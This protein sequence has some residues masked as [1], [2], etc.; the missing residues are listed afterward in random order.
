MADVA[1]ENATPVAADV[2]NRLLERAVVKSLSYGGGQTLGRDP[3]VQESSLGQPATSLRSTYRGGVSG[4]AEEAG[5][6][7][8]GY[9]LAR[10]VELPATTGLLLD[11]QL[12]D[13]IL[14]RLS[15]VSL[16]ARE[17]S[18]DVSVCQRCQGPMRVVGAAICPDLADEQRPER[19]PQRPSPRRRN[20]RCLWLQH[21]PFADGG[22][23]P[24][25]IPLSAAGEE[26][27]ALNSGCVSAIFQSHGPHDYMSP[28]RNACVCTQG[29]K[30]GR[31]S[32]S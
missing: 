23:C 2:P 18:I 13:A 26:R 12:P 17:F 25:P 30:T 20:S 24:R 15:W 19:P 10:H 21:H 32:G 8:P 14:N 7:S 27:L 9:V 29:E 4:P 11:K 5:A 3:E 22:R 1:A 28:C 6:P 16:L 31:T